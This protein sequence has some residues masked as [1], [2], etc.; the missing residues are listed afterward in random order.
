MERVTGKKLY[1][2]DFPWTVAYVLQEKDCGWRSKGVS[3]KCMNVPLFAGVWLVVFLVSVEEIPTFK[4]SAH[5]L[6]LYYLEN[7]MP[8][9]I[10]CSSWSYRGHNLP[11]IGHLQSA[12]AMDEV[13]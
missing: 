1:E 4:L 3:L 13:Y 11:F 9:N 12:L 8:K 7:G 5:L 6:I 2:I 10:I